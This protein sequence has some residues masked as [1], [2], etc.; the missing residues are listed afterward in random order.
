MTT[1]TLENPIKWTGS[2]F[3]AVKCSNET[4]CD[5]K[6][7]ALYLPPNF[8]KE[9]ESC[10]DEDRNGIIFRKLFSGLSDAGQYYYCV[11]VTC[12]K[13]G[14]YLDGPIVFMPLGDWKPPKERLGSSQC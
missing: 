7:F 2:N 6:S 14:E 10:D 4:V 11:R 8:D 1:G 5:S 12:A 13:C 9:Y 3:H